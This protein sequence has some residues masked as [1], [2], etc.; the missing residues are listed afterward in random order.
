MDERDEKIAN[1][2]KCLSA[3]ILRQKGDIPDN[4]GVRTNQVVE[5]IC[6]IIYWI[7]LKFLL[8][9][10]IFF[11]SL[12]SHCMLIY[13]SLWCLLHVEPYVVK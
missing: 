1:E 6:L 9:F 7:L 10:I 4:G 3:A 8:D 5:S 13:L 2:W 11:I 12:S